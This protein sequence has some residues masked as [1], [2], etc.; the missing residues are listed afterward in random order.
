MELDEITGAIVDA[1]IG[2][3]RGL[4]P[5]LFESVYEIVLARVLQR[6]G[7]RVARQRPITFSYEG[8]E[9]DNGFRA[10]LL[11]EECVIVEV[12]SIERVALVH[13]KQLLTYMRLSNVHVGL[14][15][16]FGA[17]LMKDGIE[18]VVHDLPPSGSPQLRVNQDAQQ[19][20]ATGSSTLITSR[21]PVEN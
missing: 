10:D 9:F 4:G 6:R 3:H 14:L 19:D 12:K 15:L 8:I 5:G 20:R 17:A 21:S 16:N 2:I 7:L 18:R 11:V 1:S 13:S